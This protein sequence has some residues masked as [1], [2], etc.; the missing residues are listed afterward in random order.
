MRNLKY[1]AVFAAL[2]LVAGVASAQIAVGV[3][4]GVAPGYV[5]GPPPVCPYGYYDYYPY[6]CAPYGY[7]GPDYFVNGVFIGAGAWFHGF[8][9]HR[10]YD[11]DDFY[12]RG[13]YRGRYGYSRGFY[14]HPGYSYRGG[15]RDGYRGGYARGRDFHGER[16][17]HGGGYHGSGG[18]HGAG[19]FRGARR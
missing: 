16:E 1:F 8:Y 11:R 4:V 10:F 9:G 19:S 6:S 5:L 2:L 13:Y 18:F 14:N 7:Y 17:F 15:Y 12:G 3:R